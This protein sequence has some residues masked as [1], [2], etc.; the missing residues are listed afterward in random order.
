MAKAKKGK[1][2]LEDALVPVEEQ[3]YEIPE[4]WCWTKIN[5]VA[6]VYT[7]NS[8]N[9]RV[10]TEKYE[11]QQSGLLFIATKDVDFDNSINYETNV[12][13]TDP[14]N[15]KKAPAN[16]ALLCIEGGS[17]GRKIGFTN[18]EVCFGN[19]LCAFSSDKIEPKYIYYFLQSN[20]FI[21]QFNDKKHGLIGGVSVKDL[22]EIGI[23]LPPLEEQKRIVEQ[24]EN[25][26]SKLDEAKEKAIDSLDETNLRKTAILD[27]AFNGNLTKSWRKQQNVLN[28]S[29]LLS[30][31]EFSKTL[32]KKDQKY[33]EECQSNC[34][35]Y[36]L[37]DG[38]VWYKT[39]I[40][41]VGVVTNGSTP[42]RKCDSYW[43][44]SIP[45]VSSGEVRNNIIIQ[46]NESITE[47]GYNNSSVKLLP[48]GTVLI[49]MIGEGKTRGQSAVLDIEATTNQNIAAI[50][51]NHGFVNSKFLW[52]WLQKQYKSNREKGAGSGPQALNCQRVREL[53]FVVP[54]IEEQNKIVEIIDAMMEKENQVIDEIEN[55]IDKIDSI[56]KSMLA[57]AFRGE[58]G[59]NIADE[60]SSIELLKSIIEA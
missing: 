8:I 57:K 36:L 30:I 20:A 46:T 6:N 21:Y 55:V 27:Y 59:T 38:T 10:K 17:A 29:T 50:I 12:R 44:G 60:E 54:T 24:I 47:E 58:L 3:P 9:E 11:G 31:S 4:N 56:K 35:E 40:G 48:K 34:E 25:L 49:A 5:S 14:E 39:I 19:K 23:A 7:G 1:L 43:N 18:Q 37:E 52:Y 32:S 22:C 13:I 45:W 2:T 42:S 16:T 15:F 51:I 53:E 26:F 28:N 33:I 41:S